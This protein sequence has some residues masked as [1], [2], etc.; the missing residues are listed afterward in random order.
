MRSTNT[1][2]KITQLQLL[3]LL[4][5]GSQKGTMTDKYKHNINDDHENRYQSKPAA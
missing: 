5:A 1:P 2:Y 4:Q 3:C